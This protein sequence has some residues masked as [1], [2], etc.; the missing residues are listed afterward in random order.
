MNILKCFLLLTLLLIG[1]Q[2]ACAQTTGQ[3]DELSQQLVTVRIQALR[4]AGS[5][6]G[7][8]TTL[9]SYQQVLNWLGEADVHTA[10]EKSHVQAQTDAPRE[11][12]EIRDRMES[13]DYHSH[14]IDAA[15][16]SKLSKQNL[17]KKLA[18]LR[19]KQDDT[20]AA[21][22]TLDEQIATEQGSANTI[23]DRFV[24]IDVRV[25]E[26]SG[27]AVTIDPDLQPSRFEASQWSVLAERKALAS[28]RKAL[29]AR[30]SSQ[31]AR[32]NR[33]KAESDE[34][35]LI[36]EGLTSAIEL[37]VKEVTSRE[38]VLE[39]KS[40]TSL[41][42]DAPGYGFVKQLTEGNSQLRVERKDLIDSL[43]T[44]KKEDLRIESQS[45]TL[46]ERFEAVQQVVSLSGN[47]P[48]LGHMLMMHWHQTDSY[49]TQMA[50][51]GVASEI[52]EHVIRRTQYE[53]LLTAIS[54]T[55]NYLSN[56]F[57][58]ETGKAD[59]DIDKN[60]LDAAKSL[61]RSK[62]ELLT[63]LIASETELINTHGSI[64]QV[65]QQLEMQLEAY[66]RYLGSR[67]LWVPSH[68]P[69][70]LSLFS[71]IK[72]ELQT[73]STKISA[74]RFDPLT[75]MIGLLFALALLLLGVQTKLNSHLQS[76]NE[77][78][79]RVREDSI[80]FTF[81]SLLITLLRGSA[82]PLMVMLLAGSLV[83]SGAEVSDFQKTD[84]FESAKILFMILL[85]RTATKENGI[86]PGHFG[87]DPATCK[88]IH[89]SATQ[90]MLWWW[91]VVLVTAFVLKLEVDSINAIT[92]RLLY[93]ISMMILGII[94]SGFLLSDFREHS[95]KGFT[96]F[97]ETFP[98]IFVT[99]FF[100][101]CILFGYLYTANMV[102][103][104]LLNSLL[105]VISLI[106]FYY[107]MQRW[108]LV[109][110]RRVR[111]N[112]ILAARQAIHEGE[113]PETG[114]E[115][116][117]LVTISASVS[118]FLKA[119]T[120]TLGALWLA[121]IWAP[122]FRAM[123]AMQRVTLWTI[124]D[125]AQG[126]TVVT[127]ITLASV[128]FA[129]FIGFITFFAAR[130]LPQLLS[131]V[132]RSRQRISPGTR[133]AVIKVLGYLI[134]TVGTLSFFS[135]LGFR[136]DRL[137]WLVAALGVGIGFGLQE[138]IANF[139]SGLIILFEKPIRV[140]DVISVGDS[141][142]RVTRIEIRATTIRDFDGK[143]LLV[144]NKEFVTGRL[145]NWT[146]SNTNIR[147]S[148]EVGIAYGS[149]VNKALA[150]LQDILESHE[151]VLEDP[152]PRALFREFGD[153]SLNLSARYF[154]SDVS[155]RALLQSDLHLKVNDAFAEAG[156]KIAFPQL[157]V[158]FDSTPGDE[159][160]S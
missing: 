24:V 28:E 79:G 158:H 114:Q 55:T 41:N 102:V 49:H 52:G 4:D 68:P 42:E 50:G 71:N 39:S 82:I 72:H 111:F 37:L 6:T 60:M 46:N 61:V 104:A 141:S 95:R 123:E 9:D 76:I 5:E 57:S 7:S 2:P 100:I 48:S 14:D 13:T 17:D 32:Y 36:L 10:A 26:L 65:R 118:Q 69:F 67:I 153:S 130:H 63:A 11:A 45:Q 107:F 47:S 127:N 91:P 77:K 56:G 92:G 22:S 140:G 27:T 74:L 106:F 23:Q 136:W 59:P 125:S 115:E 142:G 62:R 12:S 113:T 53:D 88:E 154:F 81:R 98:V 135:T 139:I 25:K 155:Q 112:E 126:E 108:L 43:A 83:I 148:L 80:R 116:N 151:M 73:L 121:Y 58:R 109:T 96:R 150:I 54:N 133:Y 85:L 128:A 157:D 78:V 29:E 51:T 132:M 143:E 103:E 93:I 31:P 119:G 84:L 110:R 137:Q 35:A 90:L 1:L 38:E 34:Q 89:H 19:T 15:S 129:L 64:D 147:R 120:L 160:L 97:G 70:S 75:P 156:I 99:G 30:L 66:Q 134:L 138:I 44:L 3:P 40:S 18:L 152:V 124:S 131:L 33:R 16:A 101:L 94:L 87:W 149:D 20:E 8:D 144:P 86:A 117:D 159:S 122:M 105:V 21:K 146:L 145:L